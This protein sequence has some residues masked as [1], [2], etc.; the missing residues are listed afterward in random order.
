M[1]APTDLVQSRGTVSWVLWT[2]D[3]PDVQ[4]GVVSNLITA[5]GHRMYGERGAGVPNYPNP[6]TGMRLG[7]GSAAP[8]YTGAGAA[9][10]TY[11]AGSHRVLAAIPA[12]SMPGAWWRIIYTCIWPVGVATTTIREVA[13]T[14]ESPLTDIPGI[15]ANTIARAVFPTPIV[16][17]ANSGL[18]VAWTHDLE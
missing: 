15:D 11:V 8:T 14:N 10:E 17:T 18:T 4:H 2:P 5:Y 3:D 7:S 13:L 9:I 12:S 16:K 1:A 6:P